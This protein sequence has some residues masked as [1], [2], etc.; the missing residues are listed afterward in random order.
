MSSASIELKG[1]AQSGAPS[2]ERPRSPWASAFSMIVS[3]AMVVCLF[4]LFALM[5]RK[6]HPAQFNKLPSG[7][8]KVLGRSAMGPR[9]QLYVIR[10]GSKLV[11]V[12]H[13]P[14]QTQPISEIADPEEAD[15][16]AGLCEANESTSVSGSFRE[17]FRQLST[18]ASTARGATK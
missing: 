3:L 7:V 14:G 2:I 5:F 12:S 18:V 1:P 13:Q 6:S 11:L 4:L 17:V 15:R 16:V 10:F 9:Q 8:V